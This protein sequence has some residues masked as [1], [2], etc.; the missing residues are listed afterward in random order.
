MLSR[1]KV[2]VF[3]L[4]VAASCAAPRAYPTNTVGM[5]FDRTTSF[6]DAPFPSDDPRKPRRR[7]RRLGEH[8]RLPQ[9]PGARHRRHHLADDRDARRRRARL[10]RGGAIFIFT[11]GSATA[12][13]PART[14]PPASRRRARAASSSS[15]SIRP[16]PTTCTGTPSPCASTSTAAACS[17]RPT[18]SRSC[19]C[20]APLRPERCTPPSSPRRRA[21]R[22]PTR[23][24][25]SPPASACPRWARRRSA[26]TGP[27]SAPS[28][29]RGS[30]RR[31]WPGS[32]SS[33]PTIPP[34]P[35]A[36][37]W[38][39][40]WRSH[41][42]APDAAFQQTD[43]FDDYCV[44]ASTLPM[45]DYQSGD[46]PYDFHST[47]GRLDVPARRDAHLPARNGEAGMVVTI[48]RAPMP[49]A[50]W[51]IAHLIRTGAGGSRPLVDRGPQ[52]TNGGPPIVP[53]S[54]PA[55][56][57]AKAGMAGASVDG[58]HEDLRNLTN[59]NED[60]L[61][62][63]INNAVALRDNVRESAA[64]YAVFARSAAGGAVV[65]LSTAPLPTT[66]P[67]RFDASKMALMGHSMGSTIS[68]LVISVGPMYRARVMSGAGGSF[69]S[70]TSSGSSCRSRCARWSTSCSGTTSSIRRGTSRRTI[71]C[72]RC[73]SGPSSRRTRSS[74][75]GRWCRSRPRGWRRGRC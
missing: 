28:S 16:R 51:P 24:P 71:R 72:S 10:R 6:Y 31:T 35:S 47:G 37:W 20:K 62:F 33:R 9:P 56:Q 14:W 32:A 23:W 67:A 63:N 43:L 66:G 36:R 18:C 44:Y 68:P 21:C 46:A 61:M 58:P 11:L 22:R 13:Q 15:A 2:L 65:R 57:F 12:G 73:S 38:P 40:C 70:R 39:T 7:R 48:P 27:P 64:E 49:A 60:F 41:V 45:P 29:R 55:R 52:A 54:G 19:P 42:P 17:A 34:P 53:G 8:R 3:V 69:G 74:T 1:L 26:S 5:R 75:R 4:P 25:P 30:P 50:G 59:D